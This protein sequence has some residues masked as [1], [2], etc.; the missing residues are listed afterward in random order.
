MKAVC[1]SAFFHLCNI[2]KIR[3]CT[4]STHCKILIQAFITSKLDYCN[5]LLSGLRQDHI[6]KLQLVQYSAARL[7]TGTRKHEHISP[8]SRSLHSLPIP[9]KIDFKL[10]LLTFKSLN[11]VAPP[12]IEEP[13]VR[14]RPT[15]TLR[16]A[17][18]GL[19]VQTKCNLTLK[20]MVT[21]I[22]HTHLLRY[23]IPCQSVYAHVV[24]TALSNQKS[25]HFF[26]SVLFS[27]NFML[28]H[29]NILLGLLL[30]VLIVKRFRSLRDRRYI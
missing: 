1:K 5:S 14:Y 26:L 2:A 29:C 4:S 21:E 10:L 30:L 3:K 17:D 25:K 16:S 23:G 28:S 19:P 15:R 18:K 7:L 11:D 13:L 9:E 12:Y 20:P 6:N 24:S 27:C 8:I 22:F